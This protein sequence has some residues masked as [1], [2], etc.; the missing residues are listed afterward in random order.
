MRISCQ[1]KMD[2]LPI[3]VVQEIVSYLSLKDRL[4][5]RLVSK[6]WKF[7][8]ET[9]AGPRSLCIYSRDYPVGLK[10]C[11]CGGEAICEDMTFYRAASDPEIFIDF[12]SRIE[13]FENLRKL[14]LYRIKMDKFLK[15]LPLLKKL[16]VLMIIQFIYTNGQTPLRI[17]LKSSSLKKFLVKNRAQ[18]GQSVVDLID[19]NTPN[20][21]SLVFL[22]HHG[23]VD[24]VK[25][26]YPGKIKHLECVEFES[27]MSELTNL[28]TLNCLKIVCPFKLT[29]FESLQKL[30]LFPLKNEESNYSELGYIKEIIISDY[31][32]TKRAT[33]KEKLRN[34]SLRFQGS[35]DRFQIRKFKFAIQFV[36]I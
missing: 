34:P 1:Q 32:Q 3:L 35:L 16:E 14:C 4:K 2:E 10:W 24:S 23:S 11:F 19:F 27:S 15:D 21:S 13:L 30:E 6:H 33:Q 36:S 5:C 26:R 29:D 17:E 8:I 28:E 18:G 9:A 25:F 20:L 22:H 7:A 12:Y 31:N